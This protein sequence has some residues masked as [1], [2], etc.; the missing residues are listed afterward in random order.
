MRSDVALCIGKAEAPAS[1]KVFMAKDLLSNARDKKVFIDVT[2]ILTL[3]NGFYV[4]KEIDKLCA[5]L[6]G[7]LVTLMYYNNI[8]IF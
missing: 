4:C 3:N 7:A 1:F 6:M 5:Y 8:L 2:G